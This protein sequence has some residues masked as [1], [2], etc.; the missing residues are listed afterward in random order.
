MTKQYF[1]YG[2]LSLKSWSSFVE[3]RAWC[4]K[5]KAYVGIDTNSWPP[6]E[7]YQQSGK[8][9][10]NATEKQHS[11]QHLRQAPILE[12]NV[13]DDF[14][15]LSESFQQ[16]VTLESSVSL[17]ETY[18]I[19][20]NLEQ[21]VAQNC[22]RSQPVSEDLHGEN[23]DNI[24]LHLPMP[25]N[26]KP[27]E[28]KNLRIVNENINKLI[29]SAQS[30][31]VNDFGHI[32]Q[33]LDYFCRENEV[34]TDIEN[35]IES[36]LEMAQTS[37]K[38]ASLSNNELI[39]YDE[40]L[41]NLLLTLCSNYNLTKKI[42][43]LRL[44]AFEQFKRFAMKQTEIE[45][46]NKV[47]GLDD[48]H[49]L[50]EN[51]AI[52]KNV[53]VFL[54]Q[55]LH[56]IQLFPMPKLTDCGQKKKKM[57]KR[58]KSIFSRVKIQILFLVRLGRGSTHLKTRSYVQTQLV[59][60][61]KSN[62]MQNYERLAYD[63]IE[64]DQAQSSGLTKMVTDKAKMVT[65]NAKKLKNW[66]NNDPSG[67]KSEVGPKGDQGKKSGFLKKFANPFNSGSSSKS[68][69]NKI[70]KEINK[71]GVQSNFET[72][73][74]SFDNGDLKRLLSKFNPEYV[75]DQEITAVI[76]FLGA[77]LA[78]EGRSVDEIEL[79]CVLLAFLGDLNDELENTMEEFCI[80]FSTNSQSQWLPACIL[81]QL[82][83]IVEI[84]QQKRAE[85]MSK[86]EELQQRDI[87]IMLSQKLEEEI[88][89][90]SDL[91]FQ[92]ILTI[93]T[94]S[95]NF[96][97]DNLIVMQLK[98]LNIS[99]WPL[100]LQWFQ[101][102]VT[103]HSDWNIVPVLNESEVHTLAYYLMEVEHKYGVKQAEALKSTLWKQEMEKSTILELFQNIY[104]HKW[105]LDE[106]TLNILSKEK[107][108]KW[109]AKISKSFK[110]KAARDI[111]D[112]KALLERNYNN[113]E[114]IR[115]NLNG[116]EN[117]VNYI[118]SKRR[119]FRSNENRTDDD[120]S[121]DGTS[122]SDSITSDDDDITSESDTSSND[123]SIAS[124]NENTSDIDSASDIDFTSDDTTSDDDGTSDI[125]CTSD[126]SSTTVSN[127]SNDVTS[128]DDLQI[129]SDHNSSIDDVNVC[130]VISKRDIDLCRKI[131][132][133][134]M[135]IYEKHGFYLR[136]TQLL[137]AIIFLKTENRGVL[138][139]VST[140][141][142]KSLIIVTLAIVKAL[143]GQ[144]VDVVTSSSVLA[145]NFKFK[146]YH[147]K[148]LN[149]P[150]SL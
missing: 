115:D 112:L 86:C 16:S 91:K 66:F 60:E 93:L 143:Q 109:T 76:E 97:L 70:E 130:N 43:I 31:T 48:D 27:M 67:S 24:K 108:T 90:E 120:F 47:E 149:L 118:I 40:A 6:Q 105:I 117:L 11:Q 33:D 150:F 45:I 18:D 72:M 57:S 64:D 119:T 137:A 106:K 88:E 28:K 79:Q 19:E 95:Q 35:G 133:V 46:E 89:T 44:V 114:V 49:V 87:L 124:N 96:Q 140:G 94:L 146:S 51:P 142:G 148:F 147:S 23:E 85:L 36:I 12:Q 107:C 15:K 131:A 1:Y 71:I 100:R 4:I 50:V 32:F 29:H 58:L 75:E 7:T 61:L 128:D 10:I 136:S 41:Y 125:D 62:A 2:N 14:K 126:G 30:A 55:E 22:K 59:L 99:A 144:N 65:D 103:V 5:R 54:V 139:Q 104:R 135:A 42:L 82:T 111:S 123:S 56:K 13:R 74:K 20:Q 83:E 145:G 121:S 8:A 110:S 63:V 73:L 37:I 21:N 132:K 78:L 92:D 138:E 68:K 17:D 113:S 102:L 101:C 3:G 26:P 39:D 129:I 77:K 116:F 122:N 34:S 81:L 52:Y 127:H 69:S 141:E 53:L 38:N 98:Q 25:L 134:D 80:L 84:N 9:A